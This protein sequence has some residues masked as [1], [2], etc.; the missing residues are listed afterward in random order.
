MRKVRL[1]KLHVFSRTTTLFEVLFNSEW[2]LVKNI[3]S[4]FQ[5]LKRTKNNLIIKLITYRKTVITRRIYE[6]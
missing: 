5:M 2:K 1:E 6:A 3:T 4:D